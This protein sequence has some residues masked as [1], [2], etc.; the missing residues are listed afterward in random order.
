VEFLWELRPGWQADGLCL[1]YPEVTWFP[2]RGQSSAPAKAVCG[3]CL[4]QR[5]CLDYALADP[6]LMGVWG[7]MSQRDR[8][9]QRTVTA[10]PAA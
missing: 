9:R 1:E 5:E 10:V 6:D 3:R 7:G 8:A 4:V 2:E